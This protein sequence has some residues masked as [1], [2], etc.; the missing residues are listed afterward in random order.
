MLYFQ[1][2]F[3][4]F[5]FVNSCQ[6]C[7]LQLLMFQAPQAQIETGAG[8]KPGP[9]RSLD[10]WGYAYKISTRSISIQGYGFSTQ[11]WQPR[12]IDKENLFIANKRMFCCLKRF[13]SLCLTFAYQNIFN[14][15]IL[16]LSLA[17]APGLVCNLLNIFCF[18]NSFQ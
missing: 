3:N 16:F 5:C 18:V 7:I 2:I 11:P 8:V 4:L 15:N 1:L 9:E 14:G 10:R 12:Y 13:I 17:E 6:K